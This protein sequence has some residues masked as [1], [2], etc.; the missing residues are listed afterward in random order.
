[1]SWTERLPVRIG[2][3]EIVSPG[4]TNRVVSTVLH[5]KLPAGPPD[6]AQAKVH[7]YLSEKTE[8]HCFATL[9]A[10]RDFISSIRSR[11]NCRLLAPSDDHANP[12]DKTYLVWIRPGA[13]I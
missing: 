13:A 10:A 5:E 8:L 1:M 6:L 3:K 12:P 11:Y 2:S 9:K 4:D 7:V